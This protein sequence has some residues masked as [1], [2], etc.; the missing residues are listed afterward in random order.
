MCTFL[1]FPMGMADIAVFD[2]VS[3]VTFDCMIVWWRDS[4]VG[5]DDDDD[6]DLLALVS[7]LV[8]VVTFDWF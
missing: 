5:V 2:G 6:D 8:G 4:G 3:V 1:L 7:V